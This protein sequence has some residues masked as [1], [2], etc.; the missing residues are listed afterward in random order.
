MASYSKYQQLLSSRLP[1]HA[2]HL[3]LHVQAKKYIRKQRP[4]RLRQ[5]EKPN[6]LVQRY[7]NYRMLVRLRM[8][9][10]TTQAK[11]L[12]EAQYSR[13]PRDPE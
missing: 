2:R 6:V 11:S 4:D 1:L 7:K 5:T 9:C 10:M 3:M 13:E 12:I 8:W